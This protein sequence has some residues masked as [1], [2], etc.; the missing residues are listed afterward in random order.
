MYDDHD[1]KHHSLARLVCWVAPLSHIVL[2]LRRISSDGSSVAYTFISSP[3]SDAPDTLLPISSSTDVTLSPELTPST[4]TPY[5]SLSS[6]AT[7]VDPASNPVLPSMIDTLSSTLALSIDPSSPIAGLS[8]LSVPY[9]TDLPVSSST[10]DI[11]SSTAVL[12]SFSAPFSFGTSSP[13][14]LST[15][16]ACPTVSAR[17][18]SC[19][20]SNGTLYFP[21]G[22]CA[23]INNSDDS[24]LLFCGR[25]YQG[26]SL[27]PLNGVSSEEACINECTLDPSCVAVGY[28]IDTLACIKRSDIDL[29]SVANAPAIIFAIQRRYYVTL[30]L[31]QP[32]ETVPPITTIIMTSADATSSPSGT[33]PIA[34]P[35]YTS[36]FPQSSPATISSA[37]D[38]MPSFTTPLAPGTYI[39]GGTVLRAVIGGTTQTYT[40]GGQTSTAISGGL[41]TT[42]T[43]GG[44]TTTIPGPAPEAT[45]DSIEDAVIGACPAYDSRIYTGP[46][47]E[48]ATYLVACGEVYN[49]TVSGRESLLKR[50]VGVECVSRCEAMVDCAALSYT[51][52]ECVFF[53]EV[54]GQ[55]D[56]DNSAFS[57][58]RLDT[59]D[60]SGEEIEPPSS[61]SQS[62]MTTTMATVSTSLSDIPAST[63][64]SVLPA[65]SFTETVTT[66]AL[67]QTTTILSISTRDTS[68]TTVV[69]P[70]STSTILITTSVPVTFTAVCPTPSPNEL[71][72]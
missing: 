38:E 62:L 36:D 4:S 37:P 24:F 6:G 15:E 57:A 58:V 46:E 59:D 27:P 65:S 5:H 31:E 64:I 47:T 42:Y 7:V 50:A 1:F 29:N 3:A 25:N 10:V 28:D 34:I 66:T 54:N 2:I 68:T 44:V 45:S 51:S 32:A 70:A 13:P 20:A 55:M 19:P 17:P 63:I 23:G 40:S 26:T 67:G 35:G 53:S 18:V 71:L 12:P 60:E 61:E 41:T 14:T 52:G 39:Y 8:S 11:S 30:Q 49:G 33:S 21:P 56:S 22:S 48:S 69:L 43:S 16:S 72:D 9:T